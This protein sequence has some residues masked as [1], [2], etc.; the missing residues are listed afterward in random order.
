MDGLLQHAR[1]AQLGP[2]E[3]SAQAAQSEEGADAAAVTPA[4][5]CA[6]GWCSLLDFSAGARP[7]QS[8]RR[9]GPHTC[10]CC[11]GA[12]HVMPALQSAGTSQLESAGLRKRRMAGQVEGRAA[13]AL[14]ALPALEASATAPGS[15][16]SSWLGRLSVAEPVGRAS[17]QCPCQRLSS[18]M[19]CLVICLPG[20]PVYLLLSL[21]GE[22]V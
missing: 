11:L 20:H 14:R 21:G 17:P 9:H 16:P 18:C 2:P 3:G 10:L 22:P 6:A 8:T 15:A 5:R 19:L 13:H 7:R 4:N 12:N 1:Q